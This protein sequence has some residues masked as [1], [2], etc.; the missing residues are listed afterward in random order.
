MDLYELKV[1]NYPTIVTME[2]DKFSNVSMYNCL[3]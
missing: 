3:L 2:Q 1:P